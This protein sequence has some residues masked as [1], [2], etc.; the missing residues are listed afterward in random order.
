MK[1]SKIKQQCRQI[2]RTNRHRR[3]TLKYTQ[4]TIKEG[5]CNGDIDHAKQAFDKT[6]KE[7]DAFLLESAVKKV[8]KGGR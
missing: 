1:N 8:N 6:C 5:S 4:N 3:Q 7:L 2:E